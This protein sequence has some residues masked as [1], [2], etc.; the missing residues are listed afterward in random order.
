MNNHI[1]LTLEPTEHMRVFKLCLKVPFTHTQIQTELEKENWVAPVETS[2]YPGH[3][4]TAVRFKLCPPGQQSTLLNQLN[5]FF[6]NEQTKTQ[7]INSMFQHIPGFD[8]D[9]MMS[10][11]ELA[12]CTILH[13][14]FTKDM[15]G[16][17]NKLHTDYR[18]LVA[19]GM[20]YFSAQ[21]DANLSTV[22]YTSAQRENPLRMPTDFC[23]GWWHANGNDTYHEGWNH[24]QT[25]RYSCLLGLTLNV[26]PAPSRP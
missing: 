13:G 2:R 12:R 14:E 8:V 21:D 17:V 25:T 22:F 6:S 10:A 4:W 15:P 5:Y 23:H 9:Y 7:L 1:S 26:T 3:E 20:V 19:T 24:T 11:E 18:K 16:F